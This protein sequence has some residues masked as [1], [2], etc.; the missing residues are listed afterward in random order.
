MKPFYRIVRAFLR[1]IA[2]AY[3]RI[4]EVGPENIPL[5]GPAIVASNH[6]SNL[7]PPLAAVTCHREL[8]FLAKE[9]L[10]RVPLFSR[11]IWALNARPINRGGVDRK[12][13]RECADILKAG[14]VLVI[15][16]E[17]TRTRDGNL[18]EAKPGAAMIAAQAGVPI[19]PAY[20]DGSF[21]AMPRKGG[22]PRPARVTVYYGKPFLPE[23]A[24]GDPAD[25]RARYEAL[26]NMMMARIAELRPK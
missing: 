16:P 3:F 1:V 17:G 8:H 24:G 12:A 11:L 6:A 25:K 20:I 10:F 13:L 4:S 26:A 15:F 9:E 23:E 7:D 5:T 22:F 21:A 2:R 18:Q 14:G 19:V